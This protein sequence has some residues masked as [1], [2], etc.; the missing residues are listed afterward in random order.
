MQ[1]VLKGLIFDYG[2]VL[3][4]PQPDSDVVAMAALLELTGDEFKPHY[5]RYRH[6]YDASEL[7]AQ[8]YWHAIASDAGRDVS[9]REVEQLTE[10]DVR[11]WIHPSP[12]MIKW[13]RLLREAGLRTAVLSNMPTALR[14]SLSERVGWM[15]EF[16][17]ETYSC[18]LGVC[19]PEPSIYKSCLEGLGT[20]AEETLFL[21]DR[22]EN[23]R[24]AQEL[25]IQAVIFTP[26]LVETGGEL[27]TRF[28]EL[29]RS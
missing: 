4:A 7:D 29:T 1:S 20:L 27:A 3:C 15:P 14:R 16:D 13:A 5:W 6:A 17:H 11:S 10:L 24:A 22:P 19:K 12:V 8:A 28:R 21:D 26:D 23:V 2:N 9:D 25:G 18:D